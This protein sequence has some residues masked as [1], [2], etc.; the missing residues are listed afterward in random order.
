MSYVHKSSSA[1]VT[2]YTRISRARLST[3]VFGVGPLRFKLRNEPVGI[4]L[5][6]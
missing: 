2:E 6:E 3:G 5:N 1:G 4:G